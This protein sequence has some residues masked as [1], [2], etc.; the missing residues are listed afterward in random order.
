MYVR[1]YVLTD[2][3]TNFDTKK[4]ALLTFFPPRSPTQPSPKEDGTGCE[5]FGGLS[6]V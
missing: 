3:I 4:L 5:K 1:G 2:L 6:M